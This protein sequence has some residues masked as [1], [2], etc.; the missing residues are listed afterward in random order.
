MSTTIEHCDPDGVRF[1]QNLRSRVVSSRLDCL[2]G[3][4][5]GAVVSDFGRGCGGAAI[6]KL[7]KRR[8]L[9]LAQRSRIYWCHRNLGGSES[10]ARLAC[11]ETVDFGGAMGK[12]TSGGEFLQPRS[13]VDRKEIA[14]CKCTGF[15]C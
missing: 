11:E 7:C 10:V 14:S 13:N 2:D 12:I 3:A 4:I 8:T 5:I 15:E 9:I 6:A 1:F